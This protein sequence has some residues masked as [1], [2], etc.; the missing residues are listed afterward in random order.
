MIKG[1]A[2]TAFTVKDMERSLEFY[3]DLIR[4]KTSIF[5]AGLK[6]QMEIELNLC[7]WI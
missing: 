6:T 1:V 7:K 4:A 3:C 5:S 2:H